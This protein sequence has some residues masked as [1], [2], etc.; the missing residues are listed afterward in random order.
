MTNEDVKRNFDYIVVSVDDQERINSIREQYG[1]FAQRLNEF[2][3]EGRLKS[4]A[5]TKLEESSMFAIK[6]ISHK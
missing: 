6:S 3:P 2:L 1:L 5:M 4:I